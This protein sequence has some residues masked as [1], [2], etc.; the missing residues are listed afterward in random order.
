MHT[1]SRSKAFLCCGEK[2]DSRCDH[3]AAQ[4]ITCSCRC[5]LPAGLRQTGQPYLF[6]ARGLAALVSTERQPSKAV[7]FL[8]QGKDNTKIKACSAEPMESGAD[9]PPSGRHPSSRSCPGARKGGQAPPQRT[10]CTGWSMVRGI[11]YQPSS[12]WS[13]VHAR[14]CAALHVS[15]SNVRALC[16][17]IN[18]PAGHD[19]MPET[20]DVC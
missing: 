13:T 5:T 2:A 11:R 3:R 4:I 15:N 10:S 1:G 18:Q 9:W 16:G 7:W 14:A 20:I 17:R 19:Y 8:R 6:S 12:T